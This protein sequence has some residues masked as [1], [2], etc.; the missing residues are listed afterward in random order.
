VW[1]II[2]ELGDYFE[3]KSSVSK[4]QKSEAIDYYSSKDS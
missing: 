1:N 2:D 4:D 3:A